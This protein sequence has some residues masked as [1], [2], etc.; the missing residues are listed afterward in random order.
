MI[1]M[2]KYFSLREIRRKKTTYYKAKFVNKSKA[3]FVK[4]SKKNNKGRPRIQKTSTESELSSL[5]YSD[6]IK[7]PWLT[8]TLDMFSDIQALI[9][10]YISEGDK[11]RRNNLW[12]SNLPSKNLFNE[13]LKV[14]LVNN[15]SKEPLKQKLY[16]FLTIVLKMTKDSIGINKPCLNL[17]QM[18]ME[19]YINNIDMFSKVSDEEE[20][21]KIFQVVKKTFE[22]NDY[23]N[24]QIMKYFD[25]SLFKGILQSFGKWRKVFKEKIDNL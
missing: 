19:S 9:L 2:A 16:D 12:I 5:K 7:N 11:N 3:K 8:Q 10:T 4:K 14:K 15:Y 23:T 21:N 22:G 24:N 18:I 6:I 25:D 20:E 13:N 1:N 17:L